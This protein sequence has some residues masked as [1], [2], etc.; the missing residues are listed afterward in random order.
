[1][2][3]R[4]G[5]IINSTSPAPFTK[6]TRFTDVATV[7]IVSLF[8]VVAFSRW[9]STSEG[10]SSE[11]GSQALITFAGIALAC[12]LSLTFWGLR[13]SLAGVRT[14]AILLLAAYALFGIISSAW[15]PNPFFSL[16]KS[17][18]MLMLVILGATCGVAAAWRQVPIQSPI[19]IALAIRVLGSLA[20][21]MWLGGSIIRMN[22]YFGRQ[23]FTFGYLHPN[24][25]AKVILFLILFL[26]PQFFSAKKTGHKLIIFLLTL[27]NGW[28]LYLTDSRTSIGI[29]L[30]AI[31]VIAAAHMPSNRLRIII[32]IAVLLIAIATALGAVWIIE[33][34]LASLDPA[35]VAEWMTLNE[36]VPLWQAMLTEA[37]DAPIAGHGYFASRLYGLQVYPWAVHSHNMIIETFLNLGMIGLFL[38][39][40]FYLLMAAFSAIV[41][42]PAA[43]VGFLAALTIEGML[44]IEVIIPGI[45][46]Y[47]LSALITHAAWRHQLQTLRS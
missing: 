9:T 20:Q 28:L 32:T 23:R 35:K 47:I 5:F 7:A 41:A 16:G 26:W 42:K 10:A 22:D 15:S 36:R 13:P 45:G 12:A 43:A 3:W 1:M 30:I 18:E 11:L 33:D 44:S 6:S 24:E 34:K 31:I 21:N 25:S 27:A 38:L 4:D 29:A 19:L 14:P 46:V 39:G 37:L 8:I 17:V 2:I 40:V